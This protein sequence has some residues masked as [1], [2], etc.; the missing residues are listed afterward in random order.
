MLNCCTFYCHKTLLDSRAAYCQIAAVIQQ[1]SQPRLQCHN[2]RCWHVQRFRLWPQRAVVPASQ[3]TSASSACENNAKQVQRSECMVQTGLSAQHSMAA[4]MQLNIGI[5][6]NPK[7]L[8]LTSGAGARPRTSHHGSCGPAAFRGTAPTPTRGSWLQ[9]LGLS[10]QQD[11]IRPTTSLCMVDH[12]QMIS[13]G[14][15]QHASGRQSGRTQGS[16]EAA[17]PVDT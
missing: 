17:E 14:Q 8:D 11:A 3:V 2:I 15:W 12:C 16:G 5:N 1:C 6:M 13:H 4:R 10:T 9:D 7:T